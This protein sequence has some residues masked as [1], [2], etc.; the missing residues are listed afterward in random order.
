MA[1]VGLGRAVR[2]QHFEGPA[3]EALAEGEVDLG[4]PLL[5]PGGHQPAVVEGLARQQLAA[6]EDRRLRLLDPADQG[7]ELGKGVGSSLEDDVLRRA[8]HPV[9][10][11]AGFELGEGHREADPHVLDAAH[12]PGAHPR[13]QADEGGV[14]EVVVVDPQGEPPAFGEAL[15]FERLDAGEGRGLLQEDADPHLQEPAGH[16]HVEVR[17]HQDVGHVD[18]QGGQLVHGGHG[19]GH[20]PLAG[21]GAGPL[22]IGIAEGRQLHLRHLRQ[23]VA[24]EAGHVASAYQ[25]DAHAPSFIYK[26]GSGSVHAPRLR[27]RHSRISD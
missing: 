21:G 2:A 3:V 13:Q 23:D 24:V 1:E 14:I 7:M 6:A 15:Q 9:G 16:G 8:E 4:R 27:E 22:A 26:D 10:E 19:R 25:G 17:R 5:A 18:P 11:V 12:P 20:P